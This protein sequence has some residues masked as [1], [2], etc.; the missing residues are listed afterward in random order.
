MREVTARKREE[1]ATGLSAG[2]K[3]KPN[4]TMTNGSL[5]PSYL[6]QRIARSPVTDEDQ[7]NTVTETAAS[8]DSSSSSSS[9]DSESSSDMEIQAVATRRKK[10][11]S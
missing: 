4:R 1:E 5:S 11:N 10:S 3:T 7:I 2:R 8:S 9:F 6:E